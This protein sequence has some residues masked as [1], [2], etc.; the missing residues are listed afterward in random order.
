MK[1]KYFVI[2]DFF[3][4][5]K[6][7]WTYERMTKEEKEKLTDLLNSNRIK[8]AVKGTYN[9][10]WETLNAIYYAFLIGLGYDCAD[11]RGNNER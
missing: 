1:N 11:W 2:F 6:Q 8:E 9:R 5:I 3:E 4:M 7:S 10:R